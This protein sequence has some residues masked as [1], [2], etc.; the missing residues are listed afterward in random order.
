MKTLFTALT[1]LLLCGCVPALSPE[2]RQVDVV[3][4]PDAPLAGEPVGEVIGSAGKWYNHIFISNPALIEGALNDLRNNTY[5]MGCDRVYVY[6]HIDFGTSV[7]FVGEAYR[8]V[9]AP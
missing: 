9:P 7:T 8:S 3:L 6:R 2:A 4:L 1:L 5:A